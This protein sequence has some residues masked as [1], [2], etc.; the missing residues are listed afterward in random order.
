V[1]EVSS[2]QVQMDVSLMSYKQKCHKIA[3]ISNGI[4]FY[5]LKPRK[6]IFVK[7]VV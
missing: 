5:T 2:H 3:F 6:L 4:L 7:C 1:D